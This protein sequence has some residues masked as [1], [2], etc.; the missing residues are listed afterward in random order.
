MR[1]GVAI[2]N[3]A[4]NLFGRREHSLV[5]NFLVTYPESGNA[6]LIGFDRQAR[7]SVC[8]GAYGRSANIPAPSSSDG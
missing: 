4:L 6:P 2:G 7:F 1:G 8:P 5:P 3:T